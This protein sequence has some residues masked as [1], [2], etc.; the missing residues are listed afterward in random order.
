MLTMQS[1]IEKAMRQLKALTDPKQLNFAIA[2]ALTQTAVE[3]QKELRRNMPS[4]FTIR[5]PWIVQGIR[6]ERATKQNLEAVV[7]SRDDFMELQETGGTKD[8]RRRYLAIPTRAV[9]RTK[10]QMIAKADR[11]GALG[12]RA[13]VVEYNGS[14]W[15]ALKKARRGANKGGQLRLLYLLIPRAELKERLGLEKDG[16]KIAP[17]RF[18]PLLEKALEEALRTAR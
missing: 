15:L 7:Y 3:V 2:K 8:P 11:P 9:R 13:E 17:E 18:G 14:K 16:L 12:E 4:R 1:D 6:V 10:T 5:R